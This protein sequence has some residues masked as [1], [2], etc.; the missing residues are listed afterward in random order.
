MSRNVGNEYWRTLTLKLLFP[1]GNR[2]PIPRSPKQ[3]LLRTGL[4]RIVSCVTN[5]YIARVFYVIINIISSFSDK[6]RG[7]DN[8]EPDAI[9][10][11][12]FYC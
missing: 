6:S 5:I 2:N 3:F 7:D 1:A 4:F 11:A 12:A 10:E 8:I 9:L